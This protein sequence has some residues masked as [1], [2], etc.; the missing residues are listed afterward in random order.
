MPPG[1]KIYLHYLFRPYVQTDEYLLWV[2]EPQKNRYLDLQPKPQILKKLVFT[3]WRISILYALLYPFTPINLSQLPFGEY[4]F[5]LDILW[6]VCLLLLAWFLISSI[7]RIG[8]EYYAISTK[9]LLV[10]RRLLW[11]RVDAAPLGLLPEFRL[12]SQANKSL[13]IR[14]AAM[15]IEEKKFRHKKILIEHHRPDLVGLS[16]E[17]AQTAYRFLQH[18]K[19]AILDQRAREIGLLK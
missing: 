15:R 17:E 6:L 16:R 4:L 1:D 18:S 13:S 7:F 8:Q 14:F 3:H 9:R 12:D 19:N 5:V 10:M 2:G 11:N